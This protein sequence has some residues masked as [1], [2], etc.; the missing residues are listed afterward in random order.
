MPSTHD[1]V[2]QPLAGHVDD[3]ERSND[4]PVLSSLEVLAATDADVHLYLH[5]QTEEGA[6]PSTR[7]LDELDG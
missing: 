6:C 3:D 5:L 7:S 1:H 2:T 4:E